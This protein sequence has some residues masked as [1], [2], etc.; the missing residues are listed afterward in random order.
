[1]TFSPET[2]ALAVRLGNGY[3]QCSVGCTESAQEIHHKLAN[4]KVNQ[5]LFPLF[6]QSVFNAC[7]INH[8]CHMTKPLPRISAHKAGIYEEYLQSIRKGE[9]NG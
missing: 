1:M 4:T 7:P 8:G 3:C 6:I 9:S 5:K 2:R